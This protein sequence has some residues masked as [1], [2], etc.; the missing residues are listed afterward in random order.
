MAKR[1]GNGEGS[2]TKRPNGTYQGR[3]RYV[4]PHTG[5]SKRVSVYG[6]TSKECR[7]KLKEIVERVA[8][9]APGRDSKESVAAW[10]A[11]WRQTSLQAS[12]RKNTTKALYA[13]ICRTYIETS[14]IGGKRLDRLR[15]NDIEEFV[16]AQRKKY[17]DS[18]VRTSYT[19]LRAA[20][21]GAVRDGLLASNPAAK[22]PRPRVERNDARS[23]TP[24]EVSQLLAKA[25][26][27]RYYAFV[28]TLAHTGLRR[29]EAAA[30]RWSDIDFE[31]R[32]LS[33]T[34][35]LVRVD[36]EP[37]LN[38]PKS[39]RSR[40]RVPMSNELVTELKA[41]RKRQKEERL[42][43]GDQ[44]L[45]H[46]E[47]VFTNALGDYVSPTNV[48]PVVRA[49][50]KAA[51]LPDDVTPHTLRHSAATA[52]LEAGV[53]IKAV[54]DLLGHGSIAITGDLYGHTTP[55][56]ARRAVDALETALGVN[57][58]RTGS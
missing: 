28:L 45:G 25:R 48:L 17:A 21:D 16:V 13:R 55:D 34:H 40:R 39:K 52:W 43:A 26:T 57:E 14:A 38:R 10:V 15:P 31:R 54:A 2:I 12:D 4:D 42:R 37:V 56:Q 19:V 36:G 58:G 20:L 7:D 53:H 30:L 50:A 5:A 46:D 6:K 44:W 49:A 29:G 33:V 8:A 51:G 11:R 24:A 41:T 47:M 27:S 32:E 22:V 3:I 23:L 9:G 18:T 1:R 35:T